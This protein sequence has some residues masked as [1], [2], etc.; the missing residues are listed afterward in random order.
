[1]CARESRSLAVVVGAVAITPTSVQHM[2]DGAK[3]GVAQWV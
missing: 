2:Q 3:K 1:V